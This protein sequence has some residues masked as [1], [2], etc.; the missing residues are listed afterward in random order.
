[1]HNI[2]YKDGYDITDIWVRNNRNIPGTKLLS[3]KILYSK[4]NSNCLKSNE[5]NTQFTTKVFCNLDNPYAIVQLGS[6]R[7]VSCQVN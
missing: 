3:T 7:I 4:K 5:I 1:M 2:G 6:I